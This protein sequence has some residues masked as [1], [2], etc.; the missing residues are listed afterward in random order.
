MSTQF[1]AG[2]FFNTR[3]YRHYLF[4][5]EIVLEA[6]TTVT[7]KYINESEKNKNVKKKQR[8]KT[9]RHG[10]YTKSSME[11]VLGKIVLKTILKIENR[12]VFSK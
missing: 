7:Y 6:Q 5:I 3:H 4:I 12:I 1:T 10:P 8:N 2:I 11:S 9:T